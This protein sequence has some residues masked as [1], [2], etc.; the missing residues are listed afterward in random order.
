MPFAPSLVPID[1]LRAPFFVSDP[2]LHAL[3][4]SS[5]LL[6]QAMR[7]SSSSSDSRT[8]KFRSASASSS[9]FMISKSFTF[10]YPNPRLSFLAAFRHRGRNSSV[11]SIPETGQDR[12]AHFIRE[13]HPCTFS[14]VRFDRLRRKHRL[15]RW[16][17]LSPF[18]LFSVKSL[19]G[20]KVGGSLTDSE[21]EKGA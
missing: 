16:R 4:L 5:R 20:V 14:L 8:R 6:I 13:T 2:E 19:L 11:H 17:A 3:G 7:V 18:S 15:R 12:F 1:A 10:I 9:L 21:L